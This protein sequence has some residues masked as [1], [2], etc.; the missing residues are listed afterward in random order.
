MKFL[1]EFDEAMIATAATETPMLDQPEELEMPC[2]EMSL[3]TAQQ[4]F[5]GI[6]N[7]QPH[8]SVIAPCP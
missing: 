7:A 1:E 5:R 3:P 2:P 8:L 6:L 4:N